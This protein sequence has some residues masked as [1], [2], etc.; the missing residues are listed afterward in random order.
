MQ[1]KADSFRLGAATLLAGALIG[2]VGGLFLHVLGLLDDGRVALIDAAVKHSFPGWLAA[3]IACLAG[4]SVAAW[5]AQRY[6]P[7][8]PQLAPSES[9]GASRS[10][11][12]NLSSL[13]VN[14][15]STCCS[16]V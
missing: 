1:G 12:S 9:T 6:A 14:C 2:L 4:A 15:F 8:A 13:T 5:L 10:P 16:A 11:P 3:M 7:D